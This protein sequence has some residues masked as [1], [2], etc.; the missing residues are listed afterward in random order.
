MIEPKYT[1]KFTLQKYK[2]WNVDSNN[3]NLGLL[4][5]PTVNDDVILE[6]QYWRR[7]YI[8][9]TKHEFANQLRRKHRD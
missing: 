3:V 5:E 4:L 2:T 7:Q 9:R 1:I 6:E 8:S